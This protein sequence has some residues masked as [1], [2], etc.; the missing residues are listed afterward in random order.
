[1]GAVLG[2]QAQTSEDLKRDGANPDNILTYGMG[3]GQQRYSKLDKI[4]KKNVK[5][6]V[7]VWSLSLENDYGEQAQPL[8]YE[9]VMY[10]SDAKW[11]V[12]IDALTGKQIWRTPV[13]FD[14]DTPVW[15]VAA[16][17]TKALPSITAS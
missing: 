15:C 5:K 12:A 17:P 1:M 3:Y 7:P 11:T 2:A 6:L 8:I 14:P 9:G 4:N 13:D 16:S 10:V